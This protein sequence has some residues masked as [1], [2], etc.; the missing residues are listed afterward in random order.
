MRARLFCLI[1]SCSAPLCSCGSEPELPNEPSWK[2]P[3]RP[4]KDTAHVLYCGVAWAV[5]KNTITLKG[6]EEQPK[7]FILS[8]PLAKGEIPK[9]SRAGLNKYFVPPWAMYR[10]S[11]VKVGDWLIIY[12]ARLGDLDICDQ[13][14]IS[15]RPGGRVPPLP[16]EAENLLRPEGVAKANNPNASEEL[17]AELRKRPHIEYHEWR[18]AHWDL[19]DKGIAYPEKFGDY[20]MFPVA[21]MPREKR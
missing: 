17:L 19:V 13:I 9:H 5:E 7:T 21:P 8:E 14:S 4:K 15:K 20:R 1:M 6:L 18:N 12:Y 3:P 11:D 10:V 16:T 2:N